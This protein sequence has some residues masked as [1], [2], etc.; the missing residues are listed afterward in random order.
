MYGLQFHHSSPF[1]RVINVYFDSSSRQ[2]YCIIYTYILLSL[3][4]LLS[5]VIAVHCN[6]RW[7]SVIM[8]LCCGIHVAVSPIIFLCLS[9]VTVSFVCA[10][11]PHP[12]IGITAATPA[13][14]DVPGWQ[15]LCCV[16]C[17]VLWNVYSVTVWLVITEHLLFVSS[18]TLVHG[19]PLAS[20]AP[21][22]VHGICP[23]WRC[24][25]NAHALWYKQRLPTCL[26]T[27]SLNSPI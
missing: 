14:A 15:W 12:L 18:D 9:A 8:P 5:T 26:Q 10:V 22:S 25:S 6:H 17:Y 16:D 1:F 7:F 23:L 20:K 13:A 2:M 11:E 4:E 24:L 19:C 21:L 3:T 27:F